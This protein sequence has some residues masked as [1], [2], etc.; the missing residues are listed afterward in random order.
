MHGPY[1][2]NDTRGE[3]NEFRH[4]SPESRKYSKSGPDSVGLRTYDGKLHFWDVFCGNSSR[5]RWPEG[6]ALH[7][8]PGADER[9]VALCHAVVV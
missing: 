9:L 5:N 1:L 3:K 8:Y 4:L 6:E 7:L 2:S